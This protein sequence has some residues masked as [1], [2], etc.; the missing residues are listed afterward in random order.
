MS[1]LPA[2]DVAVVRLLL[3]GPDADGVELVE[4][5]LLLEP[6]AEDGD[7]PGIGLA[8][9]DD[10]L[11]HDRGLLEA[12]VMIGEAVAVEVV[13]VGLLGK[14]AAEA[15][16]PSDGARLRVHPRVPVGPLVADL[17]GGRVRAVLAQVGER[18]GELLLAAP[19]PDALVV[20]TP[21]F[22]GNGRPRGR[23]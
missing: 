17:D 11:A 4:P 14:A 9:A 8:L 15:V 5:R 23:Q 1:V 20:E 21:G 12:S 13:R 16:A 10:L 18:R 22:L 19:Q 3:A 6:F 7:E 2:G